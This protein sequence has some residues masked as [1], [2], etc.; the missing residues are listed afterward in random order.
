MTTYSTFKGRFSKVALAAVIH[1]LSHLP[2][3]ALPVG[4]VLSSG[5]AKISSNSLQTTIQQST[6]NAAINWMSFGIA[7]GEQVRVLQP[8]ASSVLLN[9]VMGT[10]AS[11]IFGSLSANG[12]VFLINPNGLLFGPGS[13][14]N[15]SGL[16]ASTLN[17][18]D[19]DFLAGRYQF[20]GSSA[21][22]VVN[23]GSLIS[24][25]G[26]VALLG[27]H[28]DNQ[29]KI[30]TNSGTSNMAAGNAMSVDV[31]GG[32]L[33]NVR[34]TEG[35]LN[36]LV[37]NGGVIQAD[38][39]KIMLMAKSANDLI[40]SAVN[41]S[42]VL[43]AHAFENRNGMISL[44]SEGLN[45][46]LNVGGQLDVNGLANG[47]KGGRIELTGQQ[48]GLLGANLLASGDVGG[49]HVTVG[50]AMLDAHLQN[51][52]TRAIYI[53]G[54][55]NI[56][57]DALSI[58]DGGGVIVKAIDSTRAYG[59]I[60]AKGGALGGNGGLVETSAD[61]L[62][63]AGLRVD[64]R[65][66]KGQTGTWLLDPAD[67]TISS[68][69]TTHEALVDN[70][71]APSTGESV[72]N[73]NVGE[74]AVALNTANVVVT[75]T[76]TSVSGTGSGNINVNDALTWTAATS[77][78][79]NAAND[80]KI[81]QAITATNGTLKVNAGNDIKVLAAVTTTTGSLEFTA[82]HDIF[83]SAAT[84]ITSGHLKAIAGGNINL[85]AASTITSGDMLLR[86]DNDGS[87]P[88]ASEGTVNISC[89]PNCITLTNGTL[90]I[91]FNPVSDATLLAEL[92][93]YDGKLTGA[94]H[95]LDAK[96]WMF[97]MGVDKVYDGNTSATLVL[98]GANTGASLSPGTAT[99]SAKDVAT[100]RSIEFSGYTIS[101][102]G[103]DYLLW[104]P[105]NVAIGSGTTSAN[106]TSVPLTVST[107]SSVDKNYGE[108]VS[109][110]GF[111]V[112]GLVAGDTV[113]SVNETS[114]GASASASVA[115]GPYAIVASGAS[116][117]FVPSNYNITYVNGTL[118]VLPVPLSIS[119]NNSSKTYG[120][121]A[122][123]P[124]SGF[125]SSGLVNGDAIT[126]VVKTSTGAVATAP[127]SGS[128]YTIVPSA[129]EGTLVPGNYTISYVNG[130]LTV[131]PANLTVTANS[132][133]KTYGQ[134][135]VLSPQA[136][137]SAG[138]VN[139]DT[140]T[141]VVK[142][143]TGA[144]ATAPVSGSPYTIVPSAA[145]GTLVPGNYTI[146]YVNGALTVLP[147][148][149]TVTA[150]STSKTY[151]QTIVLSPQAFTSA[152]L[153]NGDTI[154]G[155]VKTSAGTVATAGVINGPYPIVPS[156]ASGTFVP[157]NY[158]VT[159]VNGML[160]VTPA[161]LTIT[162]NDIVKNYGESISVPVTGFSTE[163]LVNGDLVST[164][165]P[166]ST[167][168][169]AT[170]LQGA[171]Y[172]IMLDQAEG[173]KFVALN[174]SID[175]V[176]GT[177]S[178]IA[179]P[180]IVPPV[181][182]PVIPPIIPSVDPSLDP[183]A[184]PYTG[185]ILPPTDDN[186]GLTRIPPLLAIPN[187]LSSLTPETS[188]KLLVNPEPEVVVL[189]KP[190]SVPILQSSTPLTPVSPVVKDER[191][192]PLRPVIVRPRKQDRN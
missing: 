2:V 184:I 99:F 7:A 74:L 183:S 58:G 145:E 175:Y 17:L 150:N 192:L 185:Q 174:Y 186:S 13:S 44:I 33:L 8:N 80:V 62:S 170:A 154:T 11:H 147:A 103:T 155:V 135:I 36:A 116:G 66:P 168:Q 30:Q 182:P 149:L 59:Q 10:Q 18:T 97:A 73:I 54:A 169:L 85:T 48:V 34:I 132:T 71:Y 109:L 148:N 163:G 156:A 23:Q 180:V 101:G 95:T 41:T 158:T 72:A 151:G 12:Q 25:S 140:I 157:G 171:S 167:G 37:V 68:A 98:S 76:N 56:Y 137:T 90:S 104:S 42:G 108:T 144:V 123:L 126:S 50:G 96:A 190:T 81:N 93:A 138:L 134:T 52:F 32:G 45:S 121:T 166:S 86:A 164:V 6:Q 57:A 122:S 28:V 79:L 129:A 67:V 39:G 70:V 3:A 87:G 112:I 21:A 111:T 22:A 64:A 38:G 55:S 53:N 89:L 160:T 49:G 15:T 100:Q 47:Q 91:R 159:Y 92:L 35:A 117:S 26:Y 162:A 124:S 61:H 60:S 31:L 125:A 105:L 136:F 161:P 78:S 43:Q 4:G 82:V 120:Q 176:D 177:L 191:P 20:S 110:T 102:A 165:L 119:A 188:V 179:L 187:E 128:P 27:A 83:L 14:V 133:S 131:L 115:G 130:A 178:V 63:V 69:A 40:P 127:V 29:G 1:C 19:S 139:G 152:G 189:P 51:T 172:P 118:T 24:D 46:T 75:T 173:S 114:L 65:A 113:T 5:V 181:T 84:T 16:V 142:T 146:S 94:S 141:G 88:G 107:N 153:V 77:L 143:S 9:R 106:I